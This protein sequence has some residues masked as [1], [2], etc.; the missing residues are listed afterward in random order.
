M[1]SK[2][3]LASSL[4][5]AFTSF[6]ALAV[7]NGSETV[8]EDYQNHFV[9]FVAKGNE[10]VQ[11]KNCGGVLVGGKYLL[12]AHHCADG[13]YIPDLV[14]YQGINR[15]NPDETYV[16]EA[17]V[18]HSRTHEAGFEWNNYSSKLFNNEIWPRYESS[19]EGSVG[20]YNSAAYWLDIFERM[21]VYLESRPDS[22]KNSPAFNR[23]NDSDFAM[24]VLNEPIPHHGGAILSPLVDLDTGERF[25]N[26]GEPFT[27]YGWGTTAYGGASGPAA[28]TLMQA[29]FEL[30]REYP[31]TQARDGNYGGLRGPLCS[32]ESDGCRFSAA[33][34]VDFIGIDT[35]LGVPGVGSGDSGS[36]V[37]AGDYYY[38]SLFGADNDPTGDAWI[39]SVSSIGWM[40][41][42]IARAI[43]DVIYP[44]DMGIALERGNDET[45]EVS[46]PIQNFTD[47][48]MVLDPVE[49]T[50]GFEPEYFE[51]EDGGEGIEITYEDFVFVDQDCAGLL[52]PNQG[53]MVKLLLNRNQFVEFNQTIEAQIDL[54]IDGVEALP[55]TVRVL[56]SFCEANPQDPSCMD[57]CDLNPWH[58]DCID[59]CILD[60]WSPECLCE[61]LP[62]HPD[63]T[64][65][66]PQ[67]PG[68]GDNGDNDDNGDSGAGGSQGG[69]SSG[70]SVSFGLIGLFGLLLF[71]RFRLVN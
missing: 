49:V 27:F 38:G 16:R 15:N 5:L 51:P 30:Y 44:S 2:T 13:S 58:D 22:E 29:E 19:F 6:P 25:L 1:N 43:D 33:A 57:F 37:I 41:P 68:D 45:H 28:A 31:L 21:P 55:F 47:T 64:G 14:I 54:G 48:V 46:I 65:D 18:V 4:V 60:P 52:E 67:V 70:G 10:G 35:G 61:T 42:T 62:S 36:P 9:R 50:G 11:H 17:E 12:T 56:L 40:M 8:K 7:F 63:C 3:M 53:C 23:H 26:P 24:L 71:R 59:Q 34:K 39:A 20:D 32:A 66:K 69:S